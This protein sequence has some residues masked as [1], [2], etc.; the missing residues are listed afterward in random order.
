DNEA[1][2]TVSNSNGIIVSGQMGSSAQTFANLSCSDQPLQQCSGTPDGGTATANPTSGPAGT[3]VNFVVTGY[4]EGL[5][6]SY[7]WQYFN[8]QT[9]QWVGIG[10]SGSNVQLVPNGS[11]GAVLQVRFAATCS[12][13]DLTGYSNVILFTIDNTDCVPTTTGNSGYI[14]NFTADGGGVAISNLGSGPG[15]NS[16]YS[17]FSAMVVEGIPGDEIEYSVKING[18]ETVG[19]KIWVDWNDDGLFDTTELVYQSAGYSNTYSGVIAVTTSAATRNYRLR[20]GSSYTPDSGPNSACGHNGQGEFEDYTIQVVA[21]PSCIRPSN[22][23][24]SAITP[25]S[26]E[27][28]WTENNSATSWNIE[29]GPSGFVQGQAI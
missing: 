10:V 6:L 12:F 29:Y 22:L 5:G 3:S 28:S 19:L 26:A 11:H 15:Q 25:N 23:A 2:F 24:T 21:P 7:D 13:S 8:D 9:N 16:G 20:I 14:N 4:S 18:S 1:E 17:D 27:L